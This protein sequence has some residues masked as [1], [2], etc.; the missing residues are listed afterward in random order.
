L[1]FSGFKEL[2]MSALPLI[3]AVRSG[4]STAVQT[5]LSNHSNIEQADDYGWTALQWAAARG[6]TAMVELLLN[7]G[8]N[9]LHTGKDNRT[10]YQIALAATHV[11]AALLLQ[12][13]EQKKGVKTLTPPYCKAY[14]IAALQAFPDWSESTAVEDEDIVYLHQDLSVT[15]CIWHDEDVV[16]CSSSPAWAK[17]CTEELAFS[18]PTDLSL[19]AALLTDSVQ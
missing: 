6:D 15:R 4:D 10:A 13:A 16:F 7:A 5:L 14:A 12:H 19:A 3:A 2:M 9:I 8:A 17:F 1:C 18:V 11:D